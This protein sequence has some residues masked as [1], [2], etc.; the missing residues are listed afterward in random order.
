M[1]KE[2]NLGNVVTDAMVFHY[3]N[4][5]ASDAQWTDA[6]IAIQNSGS[7]TSS[8]AVSAQGS[9]SFKQM[10]YVRLS[11]LKATLIKIS[12]Q[13]IQNYDFFLFSSRSFR[14]FPYDLNTFSYLLALFKLLARLVT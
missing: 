14:F 8:I 2:C 12:S 11:K 9:I 13:I 1:L 5:S 6:S 4:L 7:I 10:F 3:A